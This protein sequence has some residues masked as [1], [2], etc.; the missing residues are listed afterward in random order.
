MHFNLIDNVLEL[1]DDH[2]VARKQVSSAEEYLADHF[3][4]FPI[5]PG[6]M[7][8]ETMVQAA[9]HLLGATRKGAWVAGEVRAVKYGA[10]VRPGQSLRVEVSISD[11]N[12]A[13]I[14]SCRGTGTIEG[15]PGDGATAI[16]GRFTMRPPKNLTAAAAQ[17]QES[18]TTCS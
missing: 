16:S 4:D 14:I 7:M 5:L 8:L 3:P 13:G 6:V 11:P 18:E 1:G 12:E 9:R 2:I 17:M 10:M 15:D